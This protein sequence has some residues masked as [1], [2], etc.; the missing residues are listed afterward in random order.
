M[1]RS[2][3]SLRKI[4][5]LIFLMLITV[6][7]T[8]TATY[9]WFST[10]RDV[11]ISGMKL[12]VEVAESMQ[13][14]LD[15]EKWAQS[16]QIANMRQFYG[17]YTGTGDSFAIYQAKK[18]ADGGNTNYVP[19]ELLP[20]SSAG[21]VQNGK[22]QFVQG[23]MSTNADGTTKLTGITACSETDLTNTA[24]I[25]DRQSNNE[26]HPYLVFDM[27]LRNVSA[28]TAGVDELQMNIGSKIW[29]DTLGTSDQEGV[30]KTGTGLE[31]SARV[32]MIIYGN[33]ISI[34]A[35]DIDGGATIGEQVRSLTS[36]GS[37][38]AAIWEP[39]DKEHTQYVVNN[40][41]RGITALQ[42][43]VTTYGIKV[44]TASA[45]PN[46]IANIDSTTDTN[47]VAVNTFKPAYTTAD[48]GT[49][50]KE[51]ITDTA[52]NNIGLAPNQI[53]K[54]RVYI[55]LEGQDPDCV[56]LAS[57]G[58]KLNVTLKLTKE[59]TNAT[60]P[61]T[62][63]GAGSSGGSSNTITAA[64]LTAEDYGGY[65]TNYT[66]T[67][68]STNGWRIFHSDGSNIYLLSNFVFSVLDISAVPA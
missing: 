43:A 12:N 55:W 11:E 67:N 57:T 50:A 22:L 39:N 30:G 54:V 51:V 65:V 41:G 9:A 18:I 36:T 38:V 40:N 49:T 19:T 5:L 47:L 44:A 34:T 42:Q 52:G 14:S 3:K 56:D 1:A 61:N 28:K 25:A 24:P 2:K 60:D 48:A 35:G 29:I 21:E 58:D 33:T 13:I 32:G 16:I 68:G 15:G 8:I 31:Y 64:T 7:M 17:T 53:S 4:K 59:Q 37:E 27:Y 23:T 63:E 45:S 20:V 10:Q 46:E 26:N 62:Y 6:V 66:P